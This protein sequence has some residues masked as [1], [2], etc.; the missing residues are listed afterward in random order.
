MGSLASEGCN[1]SGVFG[2]REHCGNR[3]AVRGRHEDMGSASTGDWVR[4]GNG[5]AQDGGDVG[6]AFAC[7]GGGY[8]Q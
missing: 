7:I 4:E 1:H 6:A 3:T 8:T 5:R 2:C